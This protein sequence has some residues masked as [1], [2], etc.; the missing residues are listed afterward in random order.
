MAMPGALADLLRFMDGLHERVQST[1][2]GTITADS[3]FPLL[4]E[5]NYAAV[6]AAAPDLT[7]REVRE[8]L[9]PLLEESGASH[10]HIWITQPDRTSRLVDDLAASD[11]TVGWDNLMGLVD[12]GR[13]RDAPAP[14][15]EHA[16]EEVVDLDGRDGF[17]ET[18]RA[19]MREFGIV[20]PPIVDQVLRRHRE[21]ME[22]AGKRWFVARVE[23]TAAG[24]GSVLVHGEAC[25]VDD[26]VT[27]PAFRRRGVARSVM[28][29]MLQA[30]ADAGAREAYLFADQPGAIG[31][32]QGVG[33]R[34]LGQ[35]VT[36]LTPRRDG[37]D[38]DQRRAAPSERPASRRSATRPASARGPGRPR[39]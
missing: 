22:P 2:W 26:V 32:Y 24:V 34:I 30:A 16:V 3:R 17:R 9:G 6:D 14:A 39:K 25:Y 31:L 13:L 1:W 28:A 37:A 20:E 7:L 21:V 29:A 35:V 4:W 38:R 11:W 12:L 10:E 8:V 36:S 5:A 18:E 33:F 23:G 15:P 19:A 27:L